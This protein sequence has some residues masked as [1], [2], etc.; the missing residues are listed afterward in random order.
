[1]RETCPPNAERGYGAGNDHWVGS[2][3][4]KLKVEGG[5]GGGEVER[6]WRGGGEEEGMNND[7]FSF[8]L[9]P[10]RSPRPVCPPPPDGLGGAE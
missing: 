4:S 10:F 7:F 2:S 3:K 6:W 8:V 5:E 1:M 9:L